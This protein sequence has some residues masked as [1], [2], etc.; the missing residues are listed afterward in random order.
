MVF[1]RLWN[2]QRNW[3][4]G[5]IN[6]IREQYKQKIRMKPD[7]ELTQELYSLGFPD[8]DSARAHLWQVMGAMAHSP[9]PHNVNLVKEGKRRAILDILNER[10]YHFQHYYAQR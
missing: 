1:D 4:E 6:R 5:V 3:D 8:I 9:T 7:N 10:A 2:P